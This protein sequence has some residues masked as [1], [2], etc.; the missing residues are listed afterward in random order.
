[1]FCLSLLQPQNI[2]LT[3]DP[4][5]GD[6]KLCDFGFARRVHSGEDIL[7]IVGTPDYVGEHCL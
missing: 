1:M 3:A 5:G 7:D 2:L 6:I 4:P